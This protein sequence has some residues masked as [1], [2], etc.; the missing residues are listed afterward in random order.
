MFEAPAVCDS[1]G[2]SEAHGEAPTEQPWQTTEKE[3]DRIFTVAA[4]FSILNCIYWCV[5]SLQRERLV[6]F[7]SSTPH[8]FAHKHLHYPLPSSLSFPFLSLTGFH[9]VCV[10]GMCLCK[11]T[12]IP[13]V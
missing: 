8:S 3:E 9:V 5:L 4:A 10:C 6:T 2:M 1:V 7:Q 12:S 13:C 11:E